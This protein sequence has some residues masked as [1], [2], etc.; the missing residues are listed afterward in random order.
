M[1]KVKFIEV[2]ESLFSMHPVDAEA[3]AYFEKTV[4]AKRV[5]AKEVEKSK[6]VKQAIVDFLQARKG[7][8]FDRTQITQ[9]LYDMGEFP[10][11]YLVNEKGTLAFN[12]ITAYANQL[13]TEK[14]LAKEEIRV[15]KVKKIVYSA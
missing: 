15:G 2:V 14:Q 5:N 6:V 9:A 4:K 12:S 3:M 10:E 11:D 7:E 1:S 8:R 13:V